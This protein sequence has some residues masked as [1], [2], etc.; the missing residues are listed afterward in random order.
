V[1]PSVV[2]PEELN[3]LINPLHVAASSVRARKVRRWTCDARLRD[4][5]Q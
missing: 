4:G 5:D 2:V 1:V 3:V